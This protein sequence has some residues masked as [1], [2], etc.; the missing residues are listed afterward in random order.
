VYQRTDDDP[1]SFEVPAA[2]HEALQAL[3]HKTIGRLM[4]LLTRHG[5][6]VEEEGSKYLADSDDDSDDERG[7]RPLQAAA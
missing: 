7:L 5:V 4:K 1:V 3:Q 6:L 2:T